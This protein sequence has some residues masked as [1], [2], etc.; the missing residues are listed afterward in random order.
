MNF[1]ERNLAVYR[2][3][4]EGKTFREISEEY[5]LSVERARQIFLNIKSKNI[6]DMDSDLYR[7]IVDDRTHNHTLT[8]YNTL[9][10]IGIDDVESLLAHIDDMNAHPE[11]YIYIGEK[12]RKYLNERVKVW[13]ETTA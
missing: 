13:H 3:R 9:R 1:K 8:L 5:G 12:G 7:L 10:R 6:E 2:M 4:M 11:N